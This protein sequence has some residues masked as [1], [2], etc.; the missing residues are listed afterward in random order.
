MLPFKLI[1]AE[2]TSAW[3]INEIAALDRLLV[4]D[5]PSRDLIPSD[6][7]KINA[8]RKPVQLHL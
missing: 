1:N 3:L 7:T 2:L 4:K 5:A 8:C 6:A